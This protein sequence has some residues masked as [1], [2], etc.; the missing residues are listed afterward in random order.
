MASVLEL[1]TAGKAKEMGIGYIDED[2][3]ALSER[4]LFD[5]GQISQR[6]ESKKTF[7]LA[8][9]MSIPIVQKRLQ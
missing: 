2:A 9:W 3:Y 7:D 6:V 8:P 5:S 1:L 4:I